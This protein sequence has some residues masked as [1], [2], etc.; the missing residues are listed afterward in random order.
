MSAITELN[1]LRVFAEVVEHGRDTA[2][3]RRAMVPAVRQLLNALM[4]GAG[5][6]GLNGPPASSPS[7]AVLQRAGCGSAPAS[8]FSVRNMP[9]ASS[10]CADAFNLPILPANPCGIPSQTSS[11]A[12]V[13]AAMARST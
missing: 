7:F 8:S 4:A 2:A 1:E 5:F 11:R 3:A 12:S 10:A 9:M 6:E 13:P